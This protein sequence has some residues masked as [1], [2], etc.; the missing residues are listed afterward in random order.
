MRT[1]ILSFFSPFLSLHPKE[2]KSKYKV[3][4]WTLH[5]PYNTHTNKEKTLEWIIEWDEIKMFKN[6]N[7][8]K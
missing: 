5:D 4:V 3:D 1:S 8:K 6:N 7:N 2:S